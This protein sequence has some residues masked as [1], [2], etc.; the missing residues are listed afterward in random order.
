MAELQATERRARFG[1][2]YPISRG[3]WS[4]EI[5]EGSRVPEPGSEE[6][7]AVAES[8]NDAEVEGGKKGTGV[9]VLLYKDGSVDLPF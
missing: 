5:T 1:R 7:S 6:E 2:L 8:G 9:V 3:D 4:K